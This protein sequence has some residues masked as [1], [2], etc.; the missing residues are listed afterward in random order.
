MKI[1]RIETIPYSIPY[2]RP[3]HFAVGSVAEAEHVLLR[4][5]TDEGLTG[6]AD[7]PPRPY[8]YG[9]TQDSIVGIVKRVFEPILVG[10]D[11]FDRELI[12]K[13]LE[14][15][16]GNNATKGAIDVALWDLMGQSLGVSCHRL[17][18]GYTDSMRVSHM[19]GIGAPEAMLE[20]ALRVREEYGITA[21]K[22]KVGRSN[23]DE[24]AAAVA[25]V[26]EGLGPDFEIGL[27]ANHGWT[28]NQALEAMERM[29]GLGLT[30]LEEPCPASEVL[31]RRRI[32]AQSRI[33][34]IS[35][36]S[37]PTPGDAARELLAGACSAI[38]IKI[39]RTGFTQSARLVGLCEGLGVDVLIGNQI[40]TQLGTLASVTFGASF[41]STSRRAGE[42][43]NFL[44]MSDDLLADPIR[45]VDGRISVRDV[46]GT[47]L[48]IDEDKLEK[49]R[50]DR[51]R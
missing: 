31:G 2:T 15:T 37:T 3:L 1:T 11:P 26:R 51:Q 25:A 44:D 36:E 16:V 28:A 49:Y 4:L 42:L 14:R 45:I 23:V 6:T 18:G 34:V 32:V 43:S 24:D 50:Q 12:H 47:G 10:R 35:D 27:D 46:P 17:L 41:E 20:D 13:D 19:V 7:V 21:V 9:E 29:S 39:T 22:L 40:D 8:T 38:N 48:L 30:V 5:H 33:P